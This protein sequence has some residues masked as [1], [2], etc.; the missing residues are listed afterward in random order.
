M[1]KFIVI[2]KHALKNDGRNDSDVVINLELVVFFGHAFEDGEPSIFVTYT[3]DGGLLLAFNNTET[4]DHYF[5]F[6]LEQSG[7]VHAPSISASMR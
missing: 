1:S 4:R 6:M 3:N 2:S 7:A 5:N